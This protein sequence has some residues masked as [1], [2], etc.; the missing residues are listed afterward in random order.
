MNEEDIIE[1]TPGDLRPPYIRG[2]I[3]GF[4]SAFVLGGLWGWLMAEKGNTWL[5]ILTFVCGFLVTCFVRC[6]MVGQKWFPV[7]LVGALSSLLGTL[8]GRVIH[9]H[10]F[11][12]GWSLMPALSGWEIMF[13]ELGVVVAGAFVGSQVRVI[14]KVW[15]WIN[16]G[17]EDGPAWE[18]RRKSPLIE[19]KAEDLIIT[20]PEIPVTQEKVEP[21]KPTE[22][23]EVPIC[24]FCGDPVKSSK[25]LFTS[26]IGQNIEP[27]ENVPLE[28]V[29]VICSFDER[30]YHGNCWKD[31]GGC[32]M[33]SCPN[34]PQTHQDSLS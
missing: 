28:E 16:S 12:G 8:F 32:S 18:R 22:E 15:K 17:P 11:S 25:Y 19:I 21:K 6:V 34:N 23:T 5:A 13:F 1:I 2:V 33:D 14:E 26:S 9:F 4:I 7:F 31:H 24:P 27:P 3:V 29:V 10:Q 30:R 20:T